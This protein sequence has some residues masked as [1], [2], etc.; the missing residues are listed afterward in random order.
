MPMLSMPMPMPMPGEPVPAQA[1]I[2]L[3]PIVVGLIVLAASLGLWAAAALAFERHR[4]VVR[5]RLLDLLASLPIV[6]TI[7]GLA[8]VST[9]PIGLI[10]AVD[11]GGPSTTESWLL[12]A[13]LIAGGSALATLATVAAARV[14]LGFGRRLVLRLATARVPDRAH[15]PPVFRCGEPVSPASAHGDVCA[16]AA[17][18]GLRAPPL[19]VR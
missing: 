6:R 17:C 15:R 7:A 3:C 14:V 9:L 19:P 8:A 10:I 16:L 18:L 5:H 2:D 13:G 4:T 11:A 1:P 12:L